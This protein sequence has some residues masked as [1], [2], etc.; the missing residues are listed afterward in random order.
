MILFPGSHINLYG[1][2]YIQCAL[3]I[4]RCPGSMTLNHIISEARYTK[5]MLASICRQGEPAI[6][7]LVASR[8]EQG[9]Q[10]R[11]LYSNILGRY[12]QLCVSEFEEFYMIGRLVLFIFKS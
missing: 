7:Q 5:I 3:V 9:R 8:M 10:S 11:A 2:E 1:G 12:Y 6:D 4:M